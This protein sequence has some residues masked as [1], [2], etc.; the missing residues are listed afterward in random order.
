MLNRSYVFSVLMTLFMICCVACASGDA[1]KNSATG[2]A[3]TAPTG[4]TA[5]PAAEIKPEASPRNDLGAAD[6]AKLKWI[7]GTWRGM[8]GDKPFY[9]RY[10]LE[11]TTLV[12]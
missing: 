1:Q 7:V 11:G 4:A 10:K 3:P 9:E 5:N 6:I 8:D 12:V 2:T